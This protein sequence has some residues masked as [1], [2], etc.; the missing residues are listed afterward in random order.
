MQSV[1]HTP[2]W[3]AVRC[4]QTCLGQYSSIRVDTFDGAFDTLE[5]NNMTMFHVR[6]VDAWII[7]E[8]E[9]LTPCQWHRLTGL[10]LECTEILKLL[11]GDEGQFRPIGDDGGLPS[12]RFPSVDM[13]LKPEASP[14]L[15]PA[16]PTRRSPP[17]SSSQEVF[18]FLLEGVSP[19]I[20]SRRSDFLS[21]ASGIS[22]SMCN[23]KPPSCRCCRSFLSFCDKPVHVR[24]ITFP[25][26][27]ILAL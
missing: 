13:T 3:R 7:D 9:F 18:I 22:V 20:R 16:Y 15:V 10:S 21:T 5:Q 26:G 4:A 25:F 1:G 19:P 2:H 11:A 8:C 27:K 6:Q 14:T 17:S 24:I 12:S 23:P